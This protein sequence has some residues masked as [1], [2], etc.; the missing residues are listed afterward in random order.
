MHPTYKEALKNGDE[1]GWRYANGFSMQAAKAEVWSER[2][3]L[4]AANLYEWL[5]RHYGES[6]MALVDVDSSRLVDAFLND[7]PYEEA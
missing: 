4:N 2:Y 3:A 1:A 5:C 7:V 6:F